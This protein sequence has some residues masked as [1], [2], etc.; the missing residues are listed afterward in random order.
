MLAARYLFVYISAMESMITNGSSKG[1]SKALLPDRKQM[2]NRSEQDFR[3]PAQ[4]VRPASYDYPIRVSG[5]EFGIVSSSDAHR[6]SVFPCRRVVGSVQDYGVNDPR[7]GVCDR[8]SSCKT[9][10]KSTEECLGHAGHI[11]LELPVFHPGFFSAIIR[12]CRTICK[13]CARVLLEKEEVDY[14]T[15]QLLR[16]M[17]T[18]QRF[19][20]IKRIQ[21]DA[22]KT[23]VC[24]R[25]GATNGDVKR[26]R[27]MRVIHDTHAVKLRRWERSAED[28]LEVDNIT[29]E[30]ESAAYMNK[31]LADHLKKGIEVLDP[32]RVLDLFSRIL[33]NEMILLG[34]YPERNHP[35]D[36]LVSTLVVPPVCARPG[37]G[38]GAS[39]SRED[40]I[41]T[42]LND[43]IVCSD[44]LKN[45]ANDVVKYAETWDILQTRVARLLD[46]QMPGFSPALR[47]LDMKSY[48]QRLKGKNGRFRGNLSGKRVDF[49]GRSVISPD[50]NLAVDELAVPLSVARVM[51]YPQRVYAHNLALMRR[52][53]RNGPSVHPGAVT[54]YLA[55]EKSRRWLRYPRDRERLA[56]RLSVGDI[57]ERHVMN[58]DMIIFNRQPSLHRM[59]MMAHRARVLPYRTFRFNVCC[60]A[61]Y[62][63]DFDGD[64][65][66]VHLV[67]TEEARAEASEL[68]LTAKNIITPKNGEPIITC[69]QDFLTAAYLV[70]AQTCFYDRSQFSQMISHWL[71]PDTLFDLPIPALLRPAELWTGKQVFELILRPSHAEKVL[72]N[73][74]AKARG[75]SGKGQHWDP[76]E[77]FVSFLDSKYISGRL[78]KKLLGGG[79]KDGLFA[80]LFALT[81]G[82][83]TARCMSRIA[84]FTSRYLQNYG[85]SLGL[86]DVSPTSSLDEEKNKALSTSFAECDRLI[87]E[88]ASGRM[89][90]IP[91]MSLKESLEAMLNSELSQVRN[92]CGSAAVR[93][94]DPRSNAPLI[95]VNSGGKGSELNTAQ[96]MACVGQQTVNGKR[97]V[98]AFEDR[99][100]PHFHR[101]AE[102]PAARGFVASSFYSGLSPTEFF[103][104]T[105]AGREGLVDTAVKTAETGYLYRR[106]SKALENVCVRYDYTVR[107]ARNEVLQLRYGEDGMDPWLM[108]GQNGLPVNL[109]L[110]WLECRALYA[111]HELRRRDAREVLEQFLLTAGEGNES[112]G[113]GRKGSRHTKERRQDQ[114]GHHRTDT[115]EEE[116]GIEKERQ[117][118]AQTA[119]QVM[120]PTS[121]INRWFKL[122][123]L[124]QLVM[125]YA[126]KLLESDETVLQEA[127]RRT[128]TEHLEQLKAEEVKKWEKEVELA[129][130][131]R[132]TPMLGSRRSIAEGKLLK[133]SDPDRN[134]PSESVESEHATSGV[135][136]EENVELKSAMKSERK[137]AEAKQKKTVCFKEPDSS[138]RSLLSS[139]EKHY[140][141]ASEAP[142]TVVTKW[143]REL[144]ERKFCQRFRQEVLKFL[145][146]KTRELRRLRELLDLPMEDKVNDLDH[147]NYHSS[148]S[149]PR[150]KS[151]KRNIEEEESRKEKRSFPLSLR[152]NEETL[153]VESLQSELL[154]MT[155]TM[156]FFFLERCAEKY[157]RKICEPGTPCGSIAAQS[158]GE[159]S[160]Q[161]T[162]RTFHFA[163]V[164]SMNITQGVPRLKELINANISI[165]TPVITVPITTS[166]EP[167]RRHSVSGATGEEKSPT[168]D[169]SAERALLRQCCL[170]VKGCIE[171]VCLKDITLEMVEVLTPSSYQ[172]HIRLNKELIEKLFL[173]V[174]AFTV[175]ER[176]LKYA[177]RP[178]SPLRL[179]KEEHVQVLS[180]DTLCVYP[181][182]QEPSMLLF[183]MK[184]LLTLLPEIMVN[185]VEQ[186]NRVMIAD[187]GRQLLAEGAELRKIML[188]P[189]VDGRKCKS[190]H[191][192]VAE[193][194]LGIEAARQT[195]VDE[196]CSIMKAY[197]INIDIRHVYLIADVMTH[198]G[199][200]L[201]ITRYGLQK[202]NNSTLTMASFERT[203]EHLYNAA[204]VQR[205]DKELDVSDSIMVGKPLPFGTNAFSLLFDEGRSTA[206]RCKDIPSHQ[207]SPS[208]NISPILPQTRKTGQ[209]PADK[210]QFLEK[211]SGLAR[212][213]SPCSYYKPL[214][215]ENTFRVDV[216]V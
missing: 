78:D 75:Y 135:L 90:P 91:G 15:F 112:D 81:N 158:V 58:G 62:N 127:E 65:M 22:Y 130:L 6:L 191:V 123:L 124:P 195:I 44:M 74:Q 28:L 37:G 85:F 110:E 41:T 142:S 156:L 214:A 29:A 39:P 211:W 164:A 145:E 128:Q 165:S 189:Y 210:L 94:L 154:P 133:L 96:M 115:E 70:T 64:E 208:L 197:S 38:G 46:A 160:T 53:V 18:Q 73:I 88:A 137:N 93:T 21:E 104:H 144:H 95:M 202:M 66:N 100:L 184:Q 2:G 27:P 179:L 121:E 188:L 119:R 99:S 204:M 82:P 89:V 51:T 69:T 176:I 155:P 185:G 206:E 3:I 162:L 199:V 136:M 106:L 26:G 169:A 196:I 118:L 125:E 4:I 108:E 35:K 151:L 97:I 60:C 182:V 103:F 111:R 146:G 42:Q 129:F 30:L 10:G 132:A 52:L 107:N 1:I 172:L 16:E 102:Y 19:A 34:F 116:V 63:A 86:Q 120:I 216:L 105:M 153:F 8:F 143:L 59:S 152:E 201:G 147:S 157:V 45:G 186:M 7:L 67:Q 17:E 49:S 183:N 213:A 180:E 50:P 212:Y 101:F 163:G 13:S 170:A 57:V 11:E 83:Y 131:M 148:S 12:V 109:E 25:C 193:R 117:R 205:K 14:F 168:P 98:N 113:A 56:A 167:I 54:V 200:V 20:L 161:M 5:V 140:C 207:S 215:A 138:S 126:E 174:D 150:K 194:T 68:M 177:A 192:A 48:A 114:D 72:L 79:A 40:D 9:C 76:N 203:T 178:L 134:E 198:R 139:S 122:S 187:N 209:L 171:R 190:N 87:K 175:R 33:P 55:V 80:R 77:G 31:D 23:H 47:S 36:M 92:T 71:G 159:P 149:R 173:L 141:K 32:V 61:P 43:I 24:S 84:A 166:L 181:F